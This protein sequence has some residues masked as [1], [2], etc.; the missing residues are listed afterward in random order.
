[1]CPTYKY[2]SAGF[3]GSGAGLIVKARKQKQCSNCLRLGHTIV[4]CIKRKFYSKLGPRKDNPWPL[5]T[6]TLTLGD[7]V[8]M[9]DLETTGLSIYH[10]EP[11][12][13]G[14]TILSVVKQ[15]K[16][17]L[18][19]ERVGTTV[20]QLT[21]TNVCITPEILCE[22]GVPLDEALK[23]LKNNIDAEKGKKQVRVFSRR[24]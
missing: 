12:E 17:S 8:V 5:P 16:A 2:V 18:K 6:I 4:T 13:I 20:S 19:L 10:Q 11:M 1:M 14:Y 9:W 23:T 21:L 15:G 3:G 7:I 24:K 22:T